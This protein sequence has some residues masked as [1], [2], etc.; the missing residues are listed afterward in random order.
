MRDND[1]ILSAGDVHVW[2]ARPGATHRTDA[3]PSILAVS[4]R[5]R[6]RAFRQE[7]DRE[8]FVL[9]RI[10][11][12]TSLSLYEPV[13][14]ADWRFEVAANGR[15]HVAAPAGTGDLEF[16]ISH[17][18]GLVAIA[19]GRTAR[20][21][22]DVES[23]YSMSEILNI[24]PTVMTS[25]ELDELANREESDRAR[26]LLRHW[27]LKEALSKACSLGL[28]MPFDRVGFRLGGEDPKLCMAPEELVGDHSR[29]KFTELNLGSGHVGAL[30]TEHGLQV[31]LREWPAALTA[32]FPGSRVD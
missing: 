20:L 29:W 16:S 12:R 25:R 14:P 28:A 19:I 13:A 30:A 15:P 24:A 26:T 6:L 3:W 31:H 22:V 1:Q 5:V 11:L 23:L 4:E 18:A 9:S 8:L 17:T 27:V 7:A 32:T 2:L 10:V 21:G